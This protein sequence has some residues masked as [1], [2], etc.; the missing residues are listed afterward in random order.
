M[1]DSR[2]LDGL[3][4]PVRRFLASFLRDGQPLPA[5]VRLSQEGRML[6]GGRFRSFAA[7]QDLQV[8]PAGFTWR[9]RVRMLPGLAVEVVDS[10]AAGRASMR[11]TLL[12][13]P[14]A[15]AGDGPELLS[16]SLHRYLG[17]AALMPS[18]LL[19]RYGVAWRAV[20]TRVATARLSERGVSVSLDFTFGPDGLVE[21]V[22]TPARNRGVAGGFV[23]TPWRGEWS[24]Y[25]LVDGMPVPRRGRVAWILD[26]GARVYW[27]GTIHD[28]AF[29]YPGGRAFVGV[30]SAGGSDAPAARTV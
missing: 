25:A 26:G 5:A 19:P 12:R 15:S 7:S 30:S 8:D 27:E 28:P 1:F 16:G 6:V 4:E 29:S 3:P 11:V 22:F 24:D 20:D 9:A 21:S 18:A 2:E 23:P 17:E 10:L 13:V 14:V